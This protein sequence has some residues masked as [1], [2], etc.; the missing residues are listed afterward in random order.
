[1]PSVF[2]YMIKVYVTKKGNFPVS[3]ARIKKTLS[4]FFAGQGVV[5][6]ADVNISIVGESEMTRIG[7]KYLSKNE[8]VHNVLSFV[9]GEQNGTFVEP[10]DNIIHLGDIVVC[11]PVAVNE[12]KSEGVLNEEKVIELLTHGA[13]HLLG[14]HHE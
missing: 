10:P 7:R 13:Y 9:S 4:E 2:L 3:A 5:S 11:Y 6:E 8:P 12:A 14:I 1:M